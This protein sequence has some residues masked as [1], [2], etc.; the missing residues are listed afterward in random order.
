MFVR[1]GD[2]GAGPCTRISAN[3]NN[4]VTFTERTDSCIVCQQEVMWFLPLCPSPA[5]NLI[6]GTFAA[7]GPYL[8]DGRTFSS[9]RGSE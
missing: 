2:H 3:R 8:D 7:P 4:P 1:C 9:R 5:Q 6:G